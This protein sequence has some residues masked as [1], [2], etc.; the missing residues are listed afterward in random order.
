MYLVQRMRGMTLI[1][2]LVGSAIMLTI[3]AGLFSMLRSVLVLSTIAQTKAGANAL[4][5]TQAEYIRSLSYDAIGTVGG[6]PAGVIAETATTTLN[7][8]TYTTNVFVQYIDSEAD[9]SGGSDS[10][11]IITDFKRARVGVTYTVQ[12]QTREA[13]RV[14]D[15]A[16]PGIETTAGGGT[17][18]VNVVNATGAAVAGATVSIE[19]D[20]VSPA[21]NL[22][23]FS[24]ATG[25][26][27]LPGAPAA[28][29]YEVTVTKS[30]YSTAQTYAQTAQNTNPTPGHLTVALNQTTTGTFAV[31]TLHTLTLTTQ[32]LETELASSTPISGAVFTLTGSKTT[33]ASGAGV[34]IYKTT[35]TDSTDG[36]GTKALSLEWDTYRLSI[37]DYDIID[38]CPAPPY[39]LAPGTSLPATLTL[40]AE[41][42]NTLLVIVY[43]ASATPV[44]DATVTLTR[45]GFS[46]QA[47]SSACGTAYFGNISSSAS[48]TVS[49][50][51]S[52][53][54][55][56]TF[57]NIS[58]SGATIYATSFP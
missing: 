28:T 41:S 39:V 52:G 12:G 5:D 32:T 49:I 8:I 50:S 4:A 23:T 17:L 3:F 54:T 24:D 38:A 14:T 6:I 37:P 40:G 58:V 29:G 57:T 48:Y 15:I 53:Y 2:V 43:D 35:V 27:F 55:D 16:P 47:T 19:N 26:V 7:G 9:G 10:N 46:A 1:D 21:I 44:P 25:T 13:I 33:G 20:T 22:T 45:T 18:R 30:G 42:A 51:K 36:A 56:T 11:G 34:P 31:D